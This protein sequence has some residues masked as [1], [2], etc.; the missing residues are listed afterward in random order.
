MHPLYSE[1]DFREVTFPLLKSTWKPRALGA[2]GSQ[3]V[4]T[5]GSQEKK[6]Q[7]ERENPDPAN[8]AELPNHGTLGLELSQKLYVNQFLFKRIELPYLFLITNASASYLMQL[9]DYWI[10]Q[11][12]SSAFFHSFI[13]SFIQ[14]TD[15]QLCIT[16]LV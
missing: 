14:Q 5:K 16:Y 8:I 9:P 1:R 15:H 7:N 2:V 4:T 12:I 6:K 13:H 10:H 11:T 3:L